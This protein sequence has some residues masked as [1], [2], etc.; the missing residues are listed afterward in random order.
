[1]STN[2]P[3]ITKE[4]EKRIPEFLDRFRKIGLDTS[5]TDKLK[6][7]IAV[8]QLFA[9][10]NK[11]PGYE[12]KLPVPTKFIHFAN[13]FDAAAFAARLALPENVRFAEAAQNLSTLKEYENAMHPKMP[14]REQVKDQASKASYGSFESY[15]VAFY[16]FINNVVA[17]QKN[18]LVDRVEDVVKECGIY[19]GFKNPEGTQC[20]IVMSEKPVEIHIKDEKLH[21]ADGMAI[22]YSD[23]A[24]F[25]C[26]EGTP[27]RTLLEMK[28]NDYFKGDKQ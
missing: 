4:H 9:E 26:I 23:G 16:S 11:Q 24:G 13:P 5:P 1:M 15:W 7:E 10:I 6:A 22:R 14:T 25:Y 28:M 3:Q 2:T 19:W 27:Y 17:K 21:N 20:V 18:P 12:N 8:T